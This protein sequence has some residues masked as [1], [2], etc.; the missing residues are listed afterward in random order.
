[1]FFTNAL[2]VELPPIIA[3]RAGLE[4]A[5]FGSR[6]NLFGIRSKIKN[7][8]SNENRT[9]HRCIASASRLLGTCTPKKEQQEL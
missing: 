7:G 4:P 2:P 9:H 5:T 1:M 6:C 3:G 8:G